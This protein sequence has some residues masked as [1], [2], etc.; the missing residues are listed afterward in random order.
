MKNKEG[1]TLVELLA[2]IVILAVILIIAI[3]QIT[4]TIK[5]TRLKS[6]EDSAKLIAT[7]AEKD[8]LAQQ[9]INQNYNVTSIPCSDVAK[10]S[11]DYSSCSITYDS[12]GVATVTLKGKK[13]SKFSNIKCTGTKD[14]MTCIEA[15]SNECIYDGDLIQGATFIEG[16][17]TYKYKQELI[18]DAEKYL[19][20]IRDIHWENVSEDGWGVALTD[21]DSTSAVVT[22]LCSSINNKPIISFAGAFAFSKASSID[23][24]SFNSPDVTNMQGMF[25]EVAADGLDF[26]KFNTTNVTNMT[27]MFTRINTDKLNL[28][29]FDTSNVTSMY[30]MF[31]DSVVE[32]IDVS[33]F[34]TANVTNMLGIF[35]GTTATKVYVRSQQELNKFSSDY[36][37]PSTL[38]FEIK[39]N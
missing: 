18:L 15:L 36:Y 34:D 4:N 25:T 7:N 39:S 31:T 24:S 17:Y 33:S 6:I 5:T 8:Y 13:N 32:E 11:N 35:S 22:D 19:Q 12:N 27:G 30:G 37:N 21:K 9:T 29:S 14:S 1:F 23:L 16:A 26:S 10:L 2:V 28:N 3:P 20:N 38:V